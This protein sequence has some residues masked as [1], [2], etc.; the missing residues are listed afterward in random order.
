MKRLV[1]GVLLF[2][3]ACT[4]DNGAS[5]PSGTLTVSLTSAGSTDGAIVLIVSGGPVTSVD[6]PS[7]YQIASHADGEGTHLMVVGNIV[8]GALATITVPDLSRA[9][10]YVA[11][12]V[13]VSDRN[14]FALLDAAKYRVTLAP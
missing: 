8:L 6:A 9:S 5:P 1:I 14:T 11:T 2:L 12:I 7:G 4:S 10:G 3:A 13:Q